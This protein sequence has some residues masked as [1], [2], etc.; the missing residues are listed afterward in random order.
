MNKIRTFLSLSAVALAALSCGPK[1]GVY[2]FD[3]FST[4]DVHGSYFDSTYVSSRTRSS[5][6]AVNHYVDSVRKARGAENVLLIDA[7]D[8]LQGDNAA[9]YFNYVDTASTHVYARM[10]NYM[11]YDAVCVGNHD[12]ETGHAVYDRVRK[13]MQ[14]P[15]FAANYPRTDGTGAYFDEYKIFKRNG[16]RIAVIGAGNANIRAWLTQSLWD[17]MDFTPI[18]SMMQAKVDSVKAVEKPDIVIVATHT[19]TGAGDGSSLEAEGLDL[20]KSLKGVDLILCAHDHR[21][22]VT[23][24]S[25]ST[26]ALINSGSHC[27]NIGH[28]SISV[29]VKG[30]KVVSKKV[31]ADLI[32]VKK[33][34]VD[35][36]MRNVFRKDYLAV[37]AFTTQ[38]VGALLSD[39]STR[40]GYTGQSD[41]LNLV[42]RL[43]L[44]QEGVE[45]SIAAPLTFDGTVKAGELIYNDLFTIYPYENQMFVVRLSGKEIKDYLEASY[46]QWI[47][48]LSTSQLSKKPSENSPALLKI[49]RRADP[50][51]GRSRWSFRARSYNFDSAAGLNYTVD[52]TKPRGSRIQ[53][54]SMADGTPFDFEKEYRVAMTSYRACGGGGLLSAAGVDPSDIDSRIVERLP[55]YRNVLYDYLK[56]HPIIDPSQ[57]GDPTVVGRWEFVPAK[58]AQPY[59]QNDLKRL[60]D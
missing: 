14:M 1:D 39:L 30:G 57:V 36:T 25:D 34:L 8:C 47:N 7:G 35:T 49:D 60:F 50:R 3:L 10:V 29:E 40:D 27:R 19:A 43:G 2:Q 58:L 12:V 17:G 51:T 15:W 33:E 59:L 28:G 6:F 31:C 13:Q 26:F 46:D 32:P 44:S 5:L 4:N 18:V 55:E 38:K 37:K 9:Y 20:F 41:Y 21:P 52:V 16:L 54:T 45:L 22:F 42:H 48:T 11:K 56:A 24:N 23:V 53:I